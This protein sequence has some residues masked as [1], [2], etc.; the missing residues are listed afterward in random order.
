M[1]R[2]MG[3][4]LGRLRLGRGCREDVLMGCVVLFMYGYE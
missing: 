1:R 3:L 2:G 4:G